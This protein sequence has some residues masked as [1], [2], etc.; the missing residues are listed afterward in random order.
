[1]VRLPALV[2]V[3][4]ICLPLAI[5]AGYA[6]ATP[7]AVKSLAT[8]GLVLG[9]LAL[10]LFMKWHHA[11][12]IASWNSF[13]IVILL[14]SQPAFGH[15]MAIGSLGMSILARTMDKNKR[16]LSAPSLTA[17]MIFMVIVVVETIFLTGGIGSRVLGSEQYGGRRYISIFAAILGYFALTAQAVPPKYRMTLALVFFLSGITGAI[18]DLAYALGP[19]FYFLYLLVSSN[20]ASLQALTQETLLRFSGLSFAS[21]AI[22]FALLLRYGI[23]GTLANP[24]RITVLLLAAAASLFGGYRSN[25]ILLV[26]V[27]ACQFYYEGL[28]RTKY[29]FIFSAGGLLAGIVVI[30]FVDRMPL[31]VQRSLSFLPLN[32]DAT[33]RQDAD[34]TLDWRLQI[35]KTVLPDVPKYLLV[36]KGYNFN[37]TDYMLTQESM[38][39]GMYNSY[40]DTII[41]GN[42]HN[43]I[44]TVL[45]PLGALGMV[46]FLWLVIAGYKVLKK[47]YLYGD[48]AIKSINTF[49]LAY[50]ISRLIFYTVFYG[51]FEGDLPILTGILGIGVA[52]N[53]GVASRRIETVTE[54][55]TVTSQTPI[56]AP[57]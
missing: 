56:L 34:G 35:W 21:L 12:L 11:I 15:V 8:V 1:M 51:Q 10:P 49:L 45:I 54:E 5:F 44:L 46:A 32:V 31:S 38:K 48:P 2:L 23:R 33:A 30:V 47:N 41:S 19:N 50:Y 39:R 24:W 27:F 36:G 14:P 53:G 20:V 7:M 26:L 40:E 42:Y 57:M 18:S 13:F 25:I 28:I 22:C 9:G 6:L 29:M 16:F 17:P 55:A 4:L 37:A 52:L 43:G 3:W